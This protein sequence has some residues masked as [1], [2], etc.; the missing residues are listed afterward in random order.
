MVSQINRTPIE[1]GRALMKFKFILMIFF[2]AN[3]AL[4]EI[5]TRRTFDLNEN[6]SPCEDFHK[7]VCSKAESQFQL[8]SDRSKHYFAFDDS[9]ERILDYK[10]QFMQN[11][12]KENKLSERTSQIKAFYKSCMN[13]AA[14]KTEELNYTKETLKYLEKVKTEKELISLST[15]EFF[16]GKFAFTTFFTK[17]NIDNSDKLEGGIMGKLM[18]LPE[19]AYYENSELLKD[20]E[21]V[22]AEFFLSLQLEKDQPKAI[23]R[24]K[25]MIAIEKEAAKTF[26]TPATQ[27][28]R[29]TENRQLTQSAILNKY[30]NLDLEY[31]FKKI[32]KD[33]LIFLPY[34]EG[35]DHLS[36]IIKNKQ[37]HSLK[38]IYLYQTLSGKMD[39]AY[40]V[41]FNKL[42][43]FQ[44]KW[45]GGA[46]S[47]P[48]LQERCTKIIMGHFAKELDETLTERMFP[49][50][51]SEKVL[52]L[53]ER[54]RASIISGI[55]KNSW[56]SVEAKQEAL[57][58]IKKMRLQL[59]KPFTDK[60]WDFLPIKKYSNKL[61]LANLDI[62]SR[63]NVEKTFDEIL[64]PFNKEA[65]GM[66]PLTVNAYF[67]SEENKFVMP[68]GILQYPFFDANLL[69]EEN[70]AAGGMVMGHEIGHSI[71]DVGSKFDSEGRLR[72]WM[73]LNDLGEFS[74]RGIKLIEQFDKIGHNGRLTQGEN[75]ADLVGLSFAYNAAFPK[76]EGNLETKKKFFISY[77]RLW[78]GVIR[79]GLNELLRKTDPHALGK[80]RIN[81][82]VKHQNG[83]QTAFQCKS[84]DKMFLA[85][86]DQVKIW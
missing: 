36:E 20:Y 10:K 54:I 13:T 24:A 73:T 39:E 65:W 23:V 79:P 63:L 14:R 81:E 2:W 29:W 64:K 4:S 43:A 31:I 47:R 8:R 74:R 30:P 21:E 41:F 6:I 68:I 61:Y 49:Q 66:S 50:F 75:V 59:V 35:L 44:K 1:Q 40:P 5:P 17:P 69:L 78:C 56:L 34:P 57:N 67:S 71:D 55:E 38:D 83:F 33:T 86:E 53:G 37:F 22:L 70:L 48:A 42:F 28:Q 84:G 7:Y 15:Q 11:I 76:N 80:A 45:F 72:Q 12:D 51:K 3:T 58:K 25:N 9:N 46:D 82:Q 52:E 18:F 26:P 62:R 19:K 32:P 85:D 60:E 27:R 77:A 16:S